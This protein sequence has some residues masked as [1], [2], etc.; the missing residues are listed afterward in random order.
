MN[1]QT[2]H[3]ALST[4]N[5]G[6]RLCTDL[7][8]L[9]VQRPLQ[10]Q[11]LVGCSFKKYLLTLSC[12]HYAKRGLKNPNLTIDGGFFHTS[13]SHILDWEAMWNFRTLI[14]AL[15]WNVVPLCQKR[16]MLEL[17][18]LAPQCPHWCSCCNHVHCQF[19][20]PSNLMVFCQIHHKFT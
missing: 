5:F 2:C 11:H 7:G 16:T 1:H 19:P 4:L 20:C 3:I 17:H 14:E 12:P 6:R 9:A 18:P 10:S 15:A 13:I 8:L